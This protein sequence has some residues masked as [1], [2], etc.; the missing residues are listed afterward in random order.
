MVAPADGYRQSG[1]RT[2]IRITAITTP[3]EPPAITFQ[4]AAKAPFSPVRACPIRNCC[5]LPMGVQRV[6]GPGSVLHPLPRDDLLGSR[7]DGEQP[8]EPLTV[9][10][11]RRSACPSCGYP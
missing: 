3:S 6:P 9:A 7:T 1:W 10:Y 2:C 11:P 5:F 4:L 8:P